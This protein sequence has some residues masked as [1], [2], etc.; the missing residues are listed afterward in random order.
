MNLC[1]LSSI[2][3]II[4]L[5]STNTLAFFGSA[6]LV[7]NGQTSPHA[8]VT[9]KIPYFS[10]SKPVEA[11]ENGFFSFTFTN[12]NAGVHPIYLVAVGDGHAQEFRTTVSL[13]ENVITAIDDIELALPKERPKGNMKKKSDLNDDERID[14]KDFS[15]LLSKWA[16]LD[17]EGDINGDG[18]VNLQDISILLFYFE[19][20]I[21]V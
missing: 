10:I 2:G 16:A 21:N 8:L 12:L 1:K 4:F 20:Q 19:L 18:W 9:I 15:I 11:D 17:T 13:I 6:E 7:V 14:M 3:I 5:L